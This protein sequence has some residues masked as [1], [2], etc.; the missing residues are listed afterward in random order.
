M[1]TTLSNAA[2]TPPSVFEERAENLSRQE[3]LNWTTDTQKD[4]EILAK[5]KGPGAK[6]LS[7]PRGSGK[8]T[9]LLRAYYDLVTSP[10][11]LP[12]Y[13]NYSRSLAL[14]PLFH[15]QSN[16]LQLFRQ[17]LLLKIVV[18]ARQAFIDMDTSVPND[19][20][21]LAD[22]GVDFIRS[23]ETGQNPSTSTFLAPSALLS[24]LEEWSVRGDFRRCVLLL[25]DAAHAFSPEQ[26]QEFFE[27]FR[28]LRSRTVSAKAA[29]YPGITS[30]SPNFHVGHE[31]EMI[32]AWIRP[33][34][35]DY[36]AMMRD[37]ALRRL[38]SLMS[39]KLKGREE[40]ID[41]LALA[42]FGIPRG[43]IVMLS[44]LL[45]IEE[46]P[47][48][49]PNRARAEAAV[50][51]HAESVRGVFCALAK[52]LP[53][54]KHF[55][56][57]GSELERALASTLRGFNQNRD[58]SKKA[59]VVAIPGPIDADLARILALLEYAGVVRSLDRVSRG[60]KGVFHRYSLHYSL[61]IR[62]NALS[63]GKAF[64]IDDVVNSLKAPL[65]HSF[66]RAQATTLLGTD[67]RQK[68]KLDL[69]PC[70]K[71]GATR[72]SLEARFCVK[73][74]ERLADAS[75]YEGLLSSPI[76]SLS[77]T[78]GKISG[79]RRY[80]TIKTVQDII[81]DDNGQEIRKVPYI[82]P[83]WAKRIRTAAEEFVSV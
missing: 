60:V 19:I 46:E 1:G 53:R 67:Y 79:L 23:L 41:L 50:G 21:A 77:L 7:G 40:L 44:Q 29:V 20:A 37:V 25:D 51:T 27:V 56:D 63:L 64:S 32:E 59:V 73:C 72:V 61:I 65:S 54:L 70:Q 2:N 57:T 78:R 43:F 52:K 62:E 3:L 14:E 71:C 45:G 39:E 48:I 8:S 42:C 49:K 66:A 16:A 22:A 81:L 36:L 12:I 74:G 28:E 24:M 18:G 5:L 11:V 38:P 13:V 68:C 17:W 83:V 30:Y 76:E 35:T 58:I 31:A 34:G 4:R 33:E 75:V 26:Q 80:T 69:A 9:L 15:K 6:L 10:Q 82:G 47:Q 55:I